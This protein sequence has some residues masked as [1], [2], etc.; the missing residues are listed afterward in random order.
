MTIAFSG[1]GEATGCT[2]STF[3][4][5]SLEITAGPCVRSLGREGRITHAESWQVITF[6]AT[7][8]DR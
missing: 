7:F 1:T 8:V 6:K 2:G 4:N 3:R 5:I